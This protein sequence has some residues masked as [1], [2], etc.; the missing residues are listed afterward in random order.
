MLVLDHTF[1]CKGAGSYDMTHWLILFVLNKVKRNFAKEYFYS[2]KIKGVFYFEAQ[3][4]SLKNLS[5]P[6]SKSNPTSNLRL[7]GQHN[8]S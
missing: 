2:V 8:W 3:I 1:D 7:A 4:N 5:Q 6:S